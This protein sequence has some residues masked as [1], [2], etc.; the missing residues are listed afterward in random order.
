MGRPPGSFRDAL[1]LSLLGKF[2]FG[3]TFSATLGLTFLLYHLETKYKIKALGIA[4]GLVFVV[5]LLASLFTVREIIERMR[6]DNAMLL[7]D[8]FVHTLYSYLMLLSFIP[9]VGPLA[10]R[11]L[12]PKEKNPFIDVEDESRLH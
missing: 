5:G 4:A 8:A 3:C 9:F 10:E 7:S 11:M 2:L 1:G 12:K 6:N